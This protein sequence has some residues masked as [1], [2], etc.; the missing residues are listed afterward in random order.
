M[1]KGQLE[2]QIK[3]GIVDTDGLDDDIADIISKSIKLCSQLDFE[4]ASKLILDSISFEFDFLGMDSDPAEYFID[5]GTIDKECDDENTQVKVSAD[6]GA[7]AITAT[8]KFSVMVIDGTDPGELQEWLD[9]NSAWACGY[10]SGGWGYTATD[11][12]NV[13]LIELNGQSVEF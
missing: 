12:D 1:A 6:D 2:F 13:S 3:R 7:L 10:L 9:E 11:G 8:H 4:Q 5:T